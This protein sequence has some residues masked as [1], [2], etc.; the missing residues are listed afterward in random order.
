MNH[1]V[2]LGQFLRSKK[3]LIVVSLVTLLCF[4]GEILA[5]KVNVSGTVVDQ[6]GVPVPGVNVMI[7]GTPNGTVTDYNGKFLLP[8]ERDAVIFFMYIGY[9]KY[10][11]RFKPNGKKEIRVKVRLV[12]DKKKYKK[13]QST[14]VIEEAP[15]N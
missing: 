15:L 9:K 3:L 7:K 5:Q 1:L 10:E 6:S 4:P 8:I 13:E 12:E 2:R 11:Q 14:A